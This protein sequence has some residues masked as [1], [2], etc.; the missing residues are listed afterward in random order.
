MYWPGGGLFLNISTL[1]VSF[2]SGPW[3][4]LPRERREVGETEED[5]GE[6]TEL[7]VYRARAGKKKWNESHKNVIVCGREIAFS[8]SSQTTARWCNLLTVMFLFFLFTA[9]PSH[10]DSENQSSIKTTARHTH[11]HT[12]QALS[13]LFWAITRIWHSTESCI[14]LCS[15]LSLVAGARSTVSLSL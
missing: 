7:T 15:T 11:T 13:G 2:C 4:C 9:L 3:D 6:T 8:V 10:L 12:H 14:C 1:L 5:T